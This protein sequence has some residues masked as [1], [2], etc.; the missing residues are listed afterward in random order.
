M[1][2]REDEI[3]TLNDDPLTLFDKAIGRPIT[4]Q[5][6]HYGLKR[7]VCEYLNP[8]LVGDPKKIQEALSKPKRQGRG[9][10]P[11]Y[12]DADY[13]ERVEEFV[14]RAKSNP[15]WAESIMITVV[16]KLME[17][18]KLPTSDPD[19]IESITIDNVI[20]P[21]KKLFTVNNITVSWPTIESYMTNEYDKKDNTLG[22]TLEQIQDMR[23]LADPMESVMIVL[24]ACSGI[25]CGAFPLEWGHVFP[26]YRVEDT[27]VWEPQDVTEDIAEKYPVVC[28]MLRVYADSYAEY[29]GFVTPEWLHILDTYRQVWIKETKTTPKPTDPLFKKAGPFVRPLSYYGIRKRLERIVDGASLRTKIKERKN[30]Y[31]IPLFNGF[32][33]FFNK[34]NKKSLSKQSKLASIILK[35][36]MMGHTGLIK[37]DK[38]YFK[39]HIEELIDEYLLAIPNLTIDDAERKALENIKLRKELSEKENFQNIVEE[40]KLKFDRHEIERDE[41]KAKMENRIKELEDKLKTDRK[42][43]ENS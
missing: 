2:I 34:Q 11:S 8:I 21:T 28:G 9:N 43:S 29:F 33:R 35:E 31:S 25:R 15:K 10:L 26:I 39:E 4:K 13:K 37:L 27:F 1:E 23:K 41:L 7:L 32:R 24:G 18:V 14:S 3:I 42:N 38:S 17:R 30:R 36:T 19:H 40:L 6:Y 20:K 5:G 22:Y 16:S 12:C